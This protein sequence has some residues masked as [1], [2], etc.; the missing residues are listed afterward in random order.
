MEDQV[1]FETLNE[2]TNNHSEKPGRLAQF[3][4]SELITLAE[5]LEIK[6][7]VAYIKKAIHSALIIEKRPRKCGNATTVRNYITFLTQR[8]IKEMR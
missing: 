5:K 6:H 8:V 7:S 1:T 2:E 3:L 4:R